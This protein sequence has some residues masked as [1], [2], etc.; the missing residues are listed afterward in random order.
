MNVLVPFGTRPEVVKLAPVVRA[1]LESGL[2]VRTVATGQHYDESLTGAFYDG[3]RLQPD[4]RWSLSGSEGER[5]G[6]MVARAFS[7]LGATRPDVVLCLGD[8]YTVPAFCIAARRHRVPV[9]HLEAGLRSFNPTSMEEV[10][11]KVAAATVSL[12]LAPTELAARF[13]AEEGIIGPGVQVVGNPV[14]DVLREMGVAP[15]PL[16]QRDR[17]VVTAHRATNVDDPVRLE[18]LVQLVASLAD[19]VG[20][21]TFPV[22]P[23]TADRL[24]AAGLRHR[25][26]RPGV[27]CCPPLPYKEMLDEL[28]TARVVVTDSG[29]LQEEASW[30]RIPVV[31]L[32]RSTPR[33]EGVE[34]GTSVLTGMDASL[35]LAAARRFASSSEQARVAAVPCPYG[36]GHT[37]QRVA[38]LLSDPATEAL[39]RIE[40]PDFVGRPFPW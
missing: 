17:V 20:P 35:A 10:N 16:A 2:S 3:L 37:S 38:T 5:F 23:R 4:T 13:L 22:H 34:T 18:A 40:E 27:T 39:L 31:V 1:L 30:L 9:A 25:L 24:A 11:R 8:T 28:R 19:E 15:V 7:E 14:I 36:D 6:E 32:R 26:E 29:G 12:H 21:V 33:W